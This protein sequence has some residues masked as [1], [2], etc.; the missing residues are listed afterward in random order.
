[1]TKLWMS[2]EV[3]KDNLK[4]VLRILEL[5]VSFFF[6]IMAISFFF[7]LELWEDINQETVEGDLSFFILKCWR[8]WRVN[9]PS[10]KRQEN[11]VWG[12]EEVLPPVPSSCACKNEP[13]Q[14]QSRLLTGILPPPLDRHPV[15]SKPT[16]LSC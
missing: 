10:C 2:S 5:L 11:R 7:L 8:G 3:L 12:L 14:D 16:P 1:M 13:L 15:C 9:Y 6:F 4:Q